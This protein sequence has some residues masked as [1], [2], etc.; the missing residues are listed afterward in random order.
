MTR[1]ITTLVILCLSSVFAGRASAQILIDSRV[2]VRNGGV[3]YRPSYATSLGYVPGVQARVASYETDHVV[4]TYETYSYDYPFVPLEEIKVLNQPVG[5][6]PA[7]LPPRTPDYQGAVTATAVIAKNEVPCV[8]P[9]PAA[10]TYQQVAPYYN[11][12]Y[13]P[14]RR[15]NMT[16][17]R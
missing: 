14:A 4:A 17:R 12:P 13:V 6:T 11:S 5:V 1:I 16:R 15:T 3:G 10:A 2:V 9:Q 8:M 7:C